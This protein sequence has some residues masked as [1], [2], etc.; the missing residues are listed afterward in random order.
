MSSNKLIGFVLLA[1]GIVLLVMGYNASQSVGSQFKKRSPVDV[2][3]G[4]V[5]LHWR[6]RGDGGRCLSGLNV[7]QVTRTSSYDAPDHPR[8]GNHRS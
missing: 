3:Q 7:S 6:S 2:R 8:Y 4:N 5:V 1:L